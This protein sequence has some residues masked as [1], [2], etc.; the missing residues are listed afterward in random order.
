VSGNKEKGCD[1]IIVSGIYDHLLDSIY[2]EFLLLLRTVQDPGMVEMH[3][4]Q[5]LQW[6]CQFE[7]SVLNIEFPLSANNKY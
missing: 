1:A 7:C 5:A 4:V 6:D 3:F 2:D